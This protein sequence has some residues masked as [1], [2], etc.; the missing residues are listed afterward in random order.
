MKPDWIYWYCNLE[1]YN[2]Y[3]SKAV[4]LE[5]KYPNEGEGK[6]YLKNSFINEINKDLRTSH[7]CI[8]SL[9]F[10]ICNDE[11]N[12]YDYDALI[13]QEIEK[14]KSEHGKENLEK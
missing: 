7:S 3:L 12:N 1:P 2:K 14:N 8:E 5:M 10:Q 4:E 13:Q 6:R 9:W 11:I